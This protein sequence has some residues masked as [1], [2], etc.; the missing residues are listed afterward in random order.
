MPTTH[1][2]VVIGAGPGGLAAAAACQ[3]EGRRVVVLEKA[4]AVGHAWRHH[5]DR[6]HLHTPA[7]LSSLPGLRIPRRYGR[8]IGRQHVVDYLEQYAR[9][10]QIDVRTGVNV[11]RVDP[12][13]GPTGRWVV[14]TSEGE[15]AAE[16]VVVATG[17]NHTPAEPTWPGMEGFTGGVVHAKDYRN[18]APYSGR[19]VLV[20]GIGNTGAE[21][22]TDLHEHGVAQV[23]IAVRTPPH[24]LRRS[25]LGT[26]AQLKGI[27]VRHLPTAVVDPVARLQAATSG[28]VPSCLSRRSRPSRARTSFSSTGDGCSPTSCSSRPATGRGSSRSSVTSASS[29]PTAARSCMAR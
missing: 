6:L 19:A 18:G 7:R 11:D 5:Y 15:L 4:D 17:Y 21:I 20:V 8:W 1:D 3:R 25:S 27:L 29:V 28:A 24:I 10:H 14:R 23:W 9:H 2:V 13:E 12:G 16:H 26:S 22:A